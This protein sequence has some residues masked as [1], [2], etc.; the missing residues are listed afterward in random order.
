MIC[1]ARLTISSQDLS[2]IHSLSHGSM[3]R[4]RR[5]ADS[6]MSTLLRDRPLPALYLLC[7]LPQADDCARNLAISSGFSHVWFRNQARIQSIGTGVNSRNPTFFPNLPPS[8]GPI[9]LESKF[10]GVIHAPKACFSQDSPASCIPS[11]KYKKGSSEP[12]S[13]FVFIKT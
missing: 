1:C 11:S 10:K 12:G 5:G 3:R 6:T 8:K 9:G 13:H 7:L 2:S 4:K